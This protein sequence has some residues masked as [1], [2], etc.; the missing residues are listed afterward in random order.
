[1]GVGVSL[2]TAPLRLFF[3]TNQPE[4]AAFV[5]Q[6]GVHRIFVDLESLGKDQRQGHLNTVKNFHTI[7][8]V[9]KVKLACPAFE[10]MARVNPWNPASPSEIEGCIQAGAD[11][12]MLPM[13][14]TR[15]EV[16]QVV[17]CIA[18]RAKLCLLAETMDALEIMDVIAPLAGVDE[19]HFGLNDLCIARGDTFM[20]QILVE[21]GLD[22][23]I[24]AVRLHG[25]PFGIGG[26]A[27]HGEGL[28][29]AELVLGEHVRLG[30]TAAILSRTFH[31]GAGSVEALQDAMNF[32]EQLELL[33]L[34]YASWGSASPEQL[35]LNK[36][37]V[38]RRVQLIV[39]SLSE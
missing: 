27:R 15:R 24:A 28:L 22:S 7:E 33:Q 8:D 37:E 38:A 32:R 16:E 17:T 26:V 19:V 13:Y 10:V 35:I 1:M 39:S 20:F 6:Q 18:G 34:A 30:S 14:R 12:I 5:C 36:A 3:I 29:P 25:I 9:R 21:G 23:A 31:R 2:P 11:V 4:I